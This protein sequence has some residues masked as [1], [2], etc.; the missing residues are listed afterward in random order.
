MLHIHQGNRTEHLLE[1]LANLLASDPADPFTA[2]TVVVQNPGMARWLT[3]GV[4]HCNGLCAQLEFPLLA[5][6]IWRIYQAGLE[7]IPERAPMAQD[8]LI[9]Q[10]MGCLPKLLDKPNYAPLRHY[11]EGDDQ[12]RK[13]YQLARRIANLFDQYLVFRPDW[14]LEWENGKASHWQAHLWHHLCAGEQPRHRARLYAE[15]R[16]RID[17]G[18]MQVSE[19]LPKRVCLFGLTA[20][21]PPYVDVL[22]AIGQVIDVHVF[23]LNPSL[24]YWGDIVDERTRARLLSWRTRFGVAGEDDYLH[25]AGIAPAC[26]PNSGNG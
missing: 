6:F 15:F 9:W 20:I 18:G 14:I 5:S 7:N 21:P 19:G 1:A 4:A 8:T 17:A 23:T 26:M 16:Q 10:L 13:R 3:R 24:A 22:R 12:E 2:E 25:P 11:L